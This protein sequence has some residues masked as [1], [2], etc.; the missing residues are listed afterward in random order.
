MVSCAWFLLPNVIYDQH[1]SLWRSFPEDVIRE[2]NLVVVNIALPPGLY[3]EGQGVE[4]SD[5][6]IWNI[7]QTF[8]TTPKI[9]NK[10]LKNIKK[11]ATKIRGNHLHHCD[12]EAELE[13]NLV[14]ATFLRN[15]IATE[16]QITMH[17]AIRKY[18]S[19]KNKSNLKSIL[20]PKDSTLKLNQIPKNLP[21]NQWKE[22]N[23]PEYINGCLIQ[24]ILAHLNQTQG[25]P[26]TIES[27]S[28]L[29]Q[30]DNFTPFGN[31]L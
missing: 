9:T 26:C 10:N 2:D 27:F 23:D 29:L 6:V 30:D 28:S 18:T 20:V 14:H 4:V 13:G 22:I 7:F 15:L 12:D 21:S 24:R 3:I 17:K 19:S 16:R 5:V 8:R 25:E 31:E 1:P 11:D